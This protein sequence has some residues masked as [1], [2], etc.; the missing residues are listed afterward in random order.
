M[1]IKLFGAD[2]FLGQLP[3]IREAF[4]SLGHELSNE[5]ELIY[6]NDLANA[7]QAIEAKKQ[8]PS[9]K[10]ILNVLDVPKH[11]WNQSDYDNAKNLLS[12][13]D[14][15]TAISQATANDVRKSLSFQASVIYNPIKDVEYRNLERD[16]PFLY[17]GRANDKNKRFDL[18]KNTIIEMGGQEKDLTIVGTDNPF[19]GNY[20]SVVDDE[21]LCELYN[22]AYFVMLPSNSE[23]IGMSSIESCVT[24]SV[25]ILNIYNKA[26]YEF[27]PEFCTIP[28]PKP[29][30]SFVSHIW[31][32]YGYYHQYILQNYT[33]QFKELFNKKTIVKNILEVYDE[34]RIR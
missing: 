16:I 5:P 6:C 4:L 24:C 14:K 18:V 27:L 1:K 13:A 26:A 12:Q 31:K 19:W 9:A 7:P 2:F 34:I 20:L 11:C 33:Y 22:R 29:M 25:P 15:I 30:A 28:D 10:L 21:K 3:R 17:V 8:Y 32:S 23:G